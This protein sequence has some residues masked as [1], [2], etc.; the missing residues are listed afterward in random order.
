MKI[1]RNKMSMVAASLRLVL[2]VGGCTPGSTDQGNQKCTQNS[3]NKK[4]CEQSSGYHSTFIPT[5]H[6]GGGDRGTTGIG[7][8]HTDGAVGG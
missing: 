2:V 7:A 3:K 6:P 4:Q 1:S 8:G 5:A